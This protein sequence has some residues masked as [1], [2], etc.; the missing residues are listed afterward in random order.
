[1]DRWFDEMEYSIG[2]VLDA[3][4]AAAGLR[5][6]NLRYVNKVLENR[7]LEKGGINTRAEAEARK[8]SGTG[9]APSGEGSLV[10]RKVL[11]DYF[12]YIRGEEEEALKDRIREV[13][14]NIPE[15][16]KVFAD[17][18][19]LN[20]KLLSIKPGEGSREARERLKAERRDAGE[21]KKDLLTGAGYPED[22]LE[23]R[24]RCGICRDTGYTD[25]GMVCSCCRKRAEEAYKW[26]GANRQV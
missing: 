24:Y 25:E 3:C 15:M 8:Q 5:D 14:R 21:R 6:P 26:I 22:Y 9:P 19:E 10:S 20:A 4:K 11:N 18:K 16:E 1:M 17:E 13:R 23:R 12:E 2:E 7:R